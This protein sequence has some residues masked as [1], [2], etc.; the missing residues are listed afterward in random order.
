M[1]L[2]L[3]FEVS[4]GVGFNFL[5]FLLKFVVHCL[6]FLD[7]F[8][9]EWGIALSNCLYFRHGLSVHLLFIIACIWISIY[10][11]VY[12]TELLTFWRELEVCYEVL[13]ILR[14]SAVFC[15]FSSI[16]S[17]SNAF[18]IIGKSGED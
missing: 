14:N 2:L 9:K 8:A 11:V 6:N 4:L 5:D 12:E 13:G 1:L 18:W 3:D 7:V 16:F 10:A 15:N 17:F